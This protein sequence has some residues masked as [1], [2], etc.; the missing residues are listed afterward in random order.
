MKIFAQLLA[1]L[2]ITCFISNAFTQLKDFYPQIIIVK[3]SELYCQ[4]SACKMQL[5]DTPLYRDE[6]HL[7]EVGAKKLAQKYLSLYPNIFK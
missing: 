3:P 4:G 5:D 7:N 1:I 2:L 6:D